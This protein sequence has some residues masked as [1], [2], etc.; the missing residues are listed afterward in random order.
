MFKAFTLIEILITFTILVISIY[1]IS[2]ITFH[3]NDL[4][5]LNSEIESLQSFL[6]QLQTKSRYEK[7][8]YTL[9]ISQ[10]NQ[11][12]S[13]CVI[14]IKKSNN[15]KKQ[16]IC[17]CLNVKQCNIADEYQLHFNHHKGTVIKNKS[18][19]P[20]SFINIDGIA[21]RLESKCI[22]LSLNKADEI[23]QLDQWGRIYVIPKHKRSHCKT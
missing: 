16:I 18:L 12:K 10:N 11:E 22:H 17:N 9:T 23:L 14:A 21:G 15:N 7:S 19:Y 6:Y 5:A 13:W 1:F 4:I 3:I 20:E 8:N 2:P